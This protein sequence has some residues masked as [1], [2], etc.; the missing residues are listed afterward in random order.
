[1]V[2]VAAAAQG[3]DEFVVVKKLASAE[4]NGSF[5]FPKFVPGKENIVFIDTNLVPGDTLKL[6]S[7]NWTVSGYTFSWIDKD[8]KEWAKFVDG[9]LVDTWFF[10][11]LAYGRKENGKVC[12]ESFECTDKKGAKRLFKI[13]YLLKFNL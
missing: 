8:G 1:M 6:T 7:E 2:S 3:A 9:N 12:M 11:K 4:R 13:K 5:V 10:Q